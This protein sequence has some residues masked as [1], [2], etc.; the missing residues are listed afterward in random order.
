[1]LDGTL[2]R[3]IMPGSVGAGAAAAGAGAAG[4]ARAAR[5]RAGRDGAAAGVLLRAVLRLPD[6]G[7]V[8]ITLMSGSVVCACAPAGASRSD[9]KRRMQGA[10]ASTPARAAIAFAFVLHRQVAPPITPSRQY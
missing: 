8:A 3:S 7:V 2:S 6:S 9:G 10:P 1:M 5:V 4:A